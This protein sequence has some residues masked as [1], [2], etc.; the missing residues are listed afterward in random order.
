[1]S[2]AMNRILLSIAALLSLTSA[3]CVRSARYYIDSGNKFAAE[4]KYDDAVIRYRNAIQKDGQSGEAYY[5]LGLAEL[6]HEHGPEAFVDLS[7]AVELSPN[8]P[9]MKLKLAEISFAAYVG[10]SRPLKIFYDKVA[11][12]ADSLLVQDPKSYEG[13]RLKGNLAM[14]DK[15]FKEAQE[16]FRKANDV[17]AD[18]PS[19]I[20]SWTQALFQDNQPEAGERLALQLIDKNKS[21]GPVYDV[22]YHRYRSLNRLVDAENILKKK[23]SNNP[24]DSSFLMQ[25]A[26][27]YSD[28]S[29]PDEMNAIFQR[30]LNDPKTYPQ[31]HLEIGDFYLQKQRWDEAVQQYQ[32]GSEAAKQKSTYLKRIADARL[33]QGKGEEVGSVVMQILK[34]EPDNKAAQ[35]VRAS[36]L[37]ADGKPENVA[38]AI[39]QFQALAE[40]NPNDPIWRYN[41]GRALLKKGDTAGA[42]AQF[43]LATKDNIDFVPPRISLAE[44]SMAKLD[45]RATL[46]Y[47]GEILAINPQLP[48]VRLQHAISLMNTG[49]EDQSGVELTNLLKEFPQSQEVQFQLAVLALK[50]KKFKDAEDRFRKLTL[51]DAGN[52]RYLTGL[53]ES[54]GSESQFDNALSIL[55]ETLKK[56]ADSPDTHSEQVRLLLADT[57]VA[58]G[59]YDLAIENY[60]ALLR[61]NGK[62]IPLYLALGKAYRLKGDNSSAVQDYQIAA[63]LA[64]KDPAPLSLLGEVQELSGHT[65]EAIESYHRAYALNPDNAALTNNLAFLIADSGGNLDEALRLAQQAVQ[66]LPDQPN[67]ADTLGY[68]Y[69]KKNLN[70]SAIQVFRGLA[71][72]YP[73]DSSFHYHFGLA[74]M[75]TGDKARARL[76]LATALSGNPPADLRRKIETAIAK[77]S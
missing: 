77:I 5:Q 74:L 8:R 21:Y 37:L 14:A 7:R 19:L 35:G 22:L 33:H 34:D 70:D 13:L 59:K 44:M 2:A 60:K 55:Q 46:R 52:M 65:Q 29:R 12:L 38:K 25:L 66:R 4:G 1:M 54:L 43:Q 71:K 61:K 41:L 51:A 31:A 15:K 48:A 45:Y 18:Q 10:D 17:K 9:D 32:Q 53:V 40:K 3:A 28:T 67:F 23:V 50:Q 26:V 36:L 62:S 39:S 6:Q 75:Q 30:M 27:F 58:A 11:S 49:K 20:L 57:A 24:S 63:A 73:N 64:P 56:T 69:L 76:E 47:T 68:V 72:K 16:F 42:Q